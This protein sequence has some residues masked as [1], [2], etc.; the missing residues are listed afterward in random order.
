MSQEPPNADSGAAALSR[1]YAEL[2]EEY[3]ATQSQPWLD[4][5]A[6]LTV[7]AGHSCPPLTLRQWMILDLQE[8]TVLSGDPDE[9][10]LARYIC[11]VASV[12]PTKRFFKRFW[13]AYKRGK[14]TI[15]AQCLI[16]CGESFSDPIGDIR[17]EKRTPPGITQVPCAPYQVQIAEMLA[18]KYGISPVDAIDWPVRCAFQIIRCHR[19]RTEEKYIAM[20]PAHLT[21]LLAEYNRATNAKTN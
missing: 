1:L 5:E 2:R 3:V 7:I 21:R 11:T 17:G 20:R 14:E 8:N 4:G 18:Q 12:E 10:D 9:A 6:R 16:H 13:R 19:Q 15:R